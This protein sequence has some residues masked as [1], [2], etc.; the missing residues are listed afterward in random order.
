MVGTG[1]PWISRSGHD[2]CSPSK[3]SLRADCPGSA[4]LERE[5]EQSD[6][7]LN[8]PAPAADRGKSLHA[9]GVD[10]LTGKTDFETLNLEPED[11]EQLKWVVERT[12]E[13][14]DRFSGTGAVVQYEVQIELDELGISGGLHGCRIDVLI[15]IPGSGFVVIDWK[16]GGSYVV[17]PEY[18]PQFWGYGWGVWK[19][20]GGNGECIKLQP[21]AWGD[22]TYQSCVF[23][24]KDFQD[25]GEK[26][27]AI[28]AATRL[29]DAPLIRGPHCEKK[30]CSLRHSACPH[31]KKSILEIPDRM[32]VVSYFSM[33]C[34]TDRGEFLDRIKVIEKVA[35]HCQE[36]IQQLAVEHGIEISGYEVGPGRSSY[37][38]AD[39][40]RFIDTLKP[41]ADAK[42]VP[43]SDLLT[44][45]IPE[46]PKS[47]SDVQKILGTSKAVVDAVKS[48]YIEMP[49]KST[50]K[51]SKL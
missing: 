24:D 40:Q 16:F 11:R 51:K 22:T 41:F 4:K 38:C 28:V 13:I 21:A 45:P 33:L 29:P 46:E 27:K 34:P 26:I 3:L 39:K 30:F 35:K 47:K 15:I 2:F 32:D 8:L 5:T 14:I 7:Q 37:T 10:V 1:S 25:L 50:L 31:W 6:L 48:L 19:K 23:E 36:T 49:G 18:N 43:V 44:K 20:Y 17:H 42:G 12:K 9:L